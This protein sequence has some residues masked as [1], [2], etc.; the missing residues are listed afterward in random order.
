MK[1]NEVAKILGIDNVGRKNM[2][3]CFGLQHAFSNKHVV[4][5]RIKMPKRG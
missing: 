5:E 3:T 2:T 4:S 1:T